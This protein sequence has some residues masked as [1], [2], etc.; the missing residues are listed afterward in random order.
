MSISIR[1]KIIQLA[2]AEIGTK[3]GYDSGDDKYIKWYNETCGTTFSVNTTPWCAIWVS[4]I[5]R[6]AGVAT[7]ILPNF[8]GCTNLRDSFAKKKGLWRARGSGYTPKKADPI[9]FDWDATGD[10]DHVGIFNYISGNK[11]YTIEG[12]TSKSVAVRSYDINSVKIAGFVEVQLEDVPTQTNPA[13]TTPDT[14]S[15]TTYVVKSG[16]NLTYIAKMFGTTVNALVEL[17]KIANPNL[18]RVGQVLKIPKTGGSTSGS[19]SSGSTTENRV[20]VVVK[21]DTL[22]GIAVKYLKNGSRWP[23]IQKLNKLTGTTIYVGQKLLVPSK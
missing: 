11:I 16:D 20:H 15:V 21:G 18:I 14:S 9:L 7:S 13:P 3:G 4:Y 23:E 17:N 22:W 5:Y 6:H 8:A 10:C 19:T 12:N 2:E 1:D